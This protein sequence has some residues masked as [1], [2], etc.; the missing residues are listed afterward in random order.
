VAKYVVN[1]RAY[2]N[3]VHFVAVNR[4]GE[5]RGTR[6]I[7]NSKII[8]TWGD[9]LAQAGGDEEQTIYAEVSLAEARQKH[10]IFKAGEFEMNFI[11]DRRP[12]LYGKIAEVKKSGL[13]A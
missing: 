4:V 3:K 8:D 2:E 1:T 7:G 11:G 10:I 13:E 9:T 6:F 12:E 5:E